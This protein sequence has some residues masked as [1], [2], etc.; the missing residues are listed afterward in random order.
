M[1]EAFT[2][3]VLLEDSAN[4]D[5][6]LAEAASICCEALE[7]AELVPKLSVVAVFAAK[8]WFEER[9]RLAF[10]VAALEPE[11]VSEAEPLWVPLAD[12]APSEAV[13]LLVWPPVVFE[14]LP[15]PDAV[16]LLVELP[17]DPA[18]PFAP[19]AARLPV[20]LK[21]PVALFAWLLLAVAPN[22]AAAVLALLAVRDAL[23][24]KAFVVALELL[25][26]LAAEAD[27]DAVA[28]LLAL[29]CCMLLSL[30]PKVFAELCIFELSSVND[31]VSLVE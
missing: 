27:S 26:L 28:V 19:A 31:V 9:F 15:P 1:D 11:L 22:V 3:A 4:C 12:N 29:A 23:C 16:L 18:V 2:L 6:L 20:E 21:L 13:L 24:A 10:N 25:E 14:V 7:D 17:D 30:A 8:F 5:D